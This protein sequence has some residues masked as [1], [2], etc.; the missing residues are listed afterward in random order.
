MPAPPREKRVLWD[1]FHSLAYPSGFFPRDDLAPHP[2]PLDWHGDHPHTNFRSVFAALR[3]LGYHV[4]VLGSPYTCFDARQYGVLLVVDPEEEFFPAEIAKLQTDVREHGLALVVIADW[5]NVDVMAQL[6][7]FDDNTR[8]WWFPETGGSNIPALNDL[9]RP[10][11]MS[12]GPDVFAGSLALH[13][14]AADFRSGAGIHEFPAG[15]FLLTTLLQNQNNVL[16][17]P[18]PQSRPSPAVTF[19]NLVPPAASD[20]AVRVPVLGLHTLSDSGAGEGRVALFGDSSCL[21]DAMLDWHHAA[22]GSPDGRC[23]WVLEA[24][25]NFATTGELGLLQDVARPLTHNFRAS[26]AELPQRA[27]AASLHL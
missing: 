1:Q 24:M 18:P 11:G 25:L 20:A 13:A 19:S 15:G 22:P 9:L 3:H 7:F 26:D 23:F 10:F 27:P 17:H 2:N 16:R 5:Y 4:D 14:H 21:D 8:N 12:F 6:R